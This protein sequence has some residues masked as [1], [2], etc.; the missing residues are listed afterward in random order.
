MPLEERTRSAR[1]DTRV[2]ATLEKLIP[3][4]ERRLEL[5]LPKG[6]VQGLTE[7]IVFGVKQAWACLFGGLLLLAI[8]GTAL[9]YPESVFIARYDF[10]FLYAISI[11]IIFVIT[12]LERPQEAIVILV[13]HFVGTAMELF[14]TA[15]GSWVYPEEAMFRIA[16]GEGSVPLFSGFMYAAVGSYIART[17]RT[18]HFRFTAYPRRL[19]TLGLAGFIYVNFFAH[20]FLPD[21]RYLLF[22]GTAILFLPTWIHYEVWRWHHR[23]PLLIGF[24]LV[25]LFIW[26]AENIA[27]LSQ[28]W[29]YPNQSNGWQPVSIQKLGSWYLLMI[30]SWV[31]VTLV[32]P[33]RTSKSRDP[34]AHN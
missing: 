31:L 15:A 19:W 2:D 1:N 24:L 9:W 16:F 8:M 27:T 3:P 4:V 17:S 22:A 30:I 26:F 34:E 13:F 33:P 18:F 21:S 23:M 7:F 28:I 11:Q 14:K 6:L 20:H 32:H 29:I 12:R 5:L 10:L 25:A